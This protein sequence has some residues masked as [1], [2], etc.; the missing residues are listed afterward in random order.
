MRTFDS[1][2]RLRCLRCDEAS[3]ALD[4]EPGMARIRFTR[5]RSAAYFLFAPFYL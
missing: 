4:Y 5:G 3:L 2:V 1:R